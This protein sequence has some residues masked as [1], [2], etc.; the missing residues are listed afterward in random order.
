[1][2]SEGE[3]AGRK[4]GNRRIWKIQAQ[5]TFFS[6]MRV[7]DF[8]FDLQECSVKLKSEF[9]ATTAP[10]SKESNKRFVVLNCKSGE[11]AKLVHEGIL[12]GQNLFTI[13]GLAVRSVLTDTSESRN[14]LQYSE[15]SAVL[16]AERRPNYFIWNAVIPT[17]LVTTF[18]GI[19]FELDL[20]PRVDLCA[21]IFLTIV[22]QRISLSSSLPETDTMTHIDRYLNVSIA[23]I[24]LAM[25]LNRMAA[26]FGYFF[27]G[28]SLCCLEAIS[29]AGKKFQGATTCTTLCP[30]IQEDAVQECLEQSLFP[31]REMYRAVTGGAD[32]IRPVYSRYVQNNCIELQTVKYFLMFA[33]TAVYLGFTLSLLRA[34]RRI[35][36]SNRALLF[37]RRSSAHMSMKA[38]DRNHHIWF[39]SED[40]DEFA[41]RL[42]RNRTSFLEE[43]ARKTVARDRFLARRT[44]TRRSL[45][46]SLTR[47][48]TTDSDGGL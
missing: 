36:K 14:G 44:L 5:G 6:T 48:R 47:S 22:A 35:R 21:T 3:R 37:S 18:A 8:P 12:I 31:W 20:V 27:F 45:M 32:Q 1:M 2:R 41:E 13:L 30:E 23:F 34:W 38:V 40:P 10:G 29:T 25:I 42:H 19:S 28:D 4:S 9:P 24:F 15:I 7:A 26:T 43:D 46:R 16:F 17:T 39:D 11:T 33:W